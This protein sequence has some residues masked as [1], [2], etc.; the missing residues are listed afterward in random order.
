MNNAVLGIS[1]ALSLFIISSVSN[2]FDVSKYDVTTVEGRIKYYCDLLVFRAP[3]YVWGG[4]FGL[5]GSDC[6]GSTNW[7]YQTA[8]VGVKRETARGMWLG[9][10]GW[11]INNTEGIEE[12][13][14]QA[15]FPNPIFFSYKKE[16]DHVGITKDVPIFYEASFSAGKYKETSLLDLK[17]YK[18][19]HGYKVVP[20]IVARSK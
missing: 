12:T 8:G 19:I 4:F 18:K 9:R 3:P 15:K 1:L 16:D 13:I 10:G 5:L 20:L 6:S 11:G 17:R 7:V 14:K 2:E